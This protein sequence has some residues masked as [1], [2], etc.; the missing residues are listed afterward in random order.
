MN[1]KSPSIILCTFFIAG[2]CQAQSLAI[3]TDGSTANSSA[4]LD[5]KSTTKGLLIPRLTKPGLTVQGSIFTKTANGT[6]LQ[7]VRK[8]TLLIGANMVMP[9]LTLHQIFHLV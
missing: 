2:L 8:A 6:G 4:L 7:T 9:I 3:N 1:I 5:I